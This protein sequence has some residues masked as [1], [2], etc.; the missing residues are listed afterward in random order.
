MTAKTAHL[1]VS[2]QFIARFGD[3]MD[4]AWFAVGAFSSLWCRQGRSE[5]IRW[6]RTERNDGYVA[7]VGA[8]FVDGMAAAVQWSNEFIVGSGG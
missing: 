2:K 3:Q 1:L 5:L 4:V 7:I 6:V 8:H